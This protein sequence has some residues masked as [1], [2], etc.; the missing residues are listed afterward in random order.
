MVH[1]KLNIWD[2]GGPNWGIAAL[3]WVT[4]Q[5]NQINVACNKQTWQETGAQRSAQNNVL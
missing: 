2:T 3:E 5:E 1:I 4:L